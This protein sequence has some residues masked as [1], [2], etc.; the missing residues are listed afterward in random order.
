MAGAHGITSIMV[1]LRVVE[2]NSHVLPKKAASHINK[3]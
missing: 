1:Y 2:E 3:R